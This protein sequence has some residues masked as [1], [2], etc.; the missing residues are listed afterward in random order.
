M[1]PG[2]NYTGRDLGW[3]MPLRPNPVT[4]RAPVFL[5]VMLTRSRGR[6]SHQ[7][8]TPAHAIMPRTDR[9]PWPAH[10]EIRR[11]FRSPVFRRSLGVP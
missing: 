9:L 5:H 11:R 8:G 10:K 7:S 3:P 2:A 4:T 6:R 1:T